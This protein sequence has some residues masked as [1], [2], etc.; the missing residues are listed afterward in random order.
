MRDNALKSLG[1]FLQTPKEIPSL[2]L[3]KLWRAL[4]YSMWFCD[5]PLTQQAL[6]DDLAN[7]VTTISPINFATFL[8][9]FWVIMAREWEGLDRYRLDKF[10]LLLRRYFAA[11]L[12]RLKAQNWDEDWV[13]DFLKLME[14]I[15]L[16]LDETKVPNGIRFHIFDIFLDE[17]ERVMKE[18]DIAFTKGIS[19]SKGK[20]KT[21]AAPPQEEKF[22]TD[23]VP[24]YHT[25]NSDGEEESDEDGDEDNSDDSDE[26]EDEG[27]VEETEE[28]KALN[29]HIAKKNQ[30]E[31]QTEREKEWEVIAK[32]I[33]ENDV[34]LKKL[35]KSVETLA[36][37]SKFRLLREAAQE[38][39]DDERLCVWGI[40]NPKPKDEDDDDEFTGF[41]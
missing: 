39:L 27:W 20:K 23:N 22:E 16:N 37:K 13:D 36:T 8:D 21:K 35:L 29:E 4:F 34:P 17:F 11:T 9:A 6:A 3:L 40:A 30:E 26:E 7:L 19:A 5:R 10:Y 1:V 32:K 33:K 41:D 18:D 2:E 15:P 38:V 25:V 24:E 31:E 14:H 28:E 12:R